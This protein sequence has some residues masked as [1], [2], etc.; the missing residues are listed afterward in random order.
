MYDSADQLERDGTF[1]LTSPLLNIQT[2]YENITIAIER[3]EHKHKSTFQDMREFFIR[4]EKTKGMKMTVRK[5][6]EVASNSV[7]V[8][9]QTLQQK[10]FNFSSSRLSLGK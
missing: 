4:D 6:K 8:I 5:I 7:S 3:S 1:F 2:W 10:I 9:T